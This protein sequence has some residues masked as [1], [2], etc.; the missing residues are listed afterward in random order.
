[1]HT[2]CTL[3]HSIMG[4]KTARVGYRSAA[5]ALNDLVAGHVDFACSSLGG[6]AP[7]I[8]A[9]TI[10]AIAIASPERAD[11]IKDVPTT[12]E[13]GL[14]EFQVSGW[15]AIFAPR[16]TPQDIQAKLNDALLK[17]LDDEGTRK[18]L[19]DIGCVIPNKADRTPQALQKRV[20][21]EVARWSSVLKAAGN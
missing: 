10:K 8:Q 14:P 12:T 18:R 4:T 11:V 5:P 17:A 20:E 1:M 15:N 6:V 7:L 21:S 2:Y 19:V 9:G 13:G 16:N 3:L